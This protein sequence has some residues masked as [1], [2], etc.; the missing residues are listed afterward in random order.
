MSGNTNAPWKDEELLRQ[1]YYEEDLTIAEIAELWSTS[2]DTIRYYKDKFEIPNKRIWDT[3]DVEEIERL[4]WQ[5]G[6]SLKQLGEHYDTGGV[7][8]LKFMVQN[9]IPRRTPDQEKGTGW[10]EP[11]RLERLYWDEGLTLE[12]IGNKLGCSASTVSDWMKRLG[13]D[14]EKIPEEKPPYHRWN[15]DGYEEVKTKIEGVT[16]SIRIHRLVA[17][18]MGELDPNDFRNPKINVHHKNGVRWDNR[19]DNLEVMSKSEHHSH[20]YKEREIDDNGRIIR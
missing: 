9:N 13:V 19:P 2:Y 14:R 11:D 18:A 8:V 12:E 20:H 10:K 3:F 4:Y 6:Y 1:K 15:R 16:Y 5:E 7:H 17:V